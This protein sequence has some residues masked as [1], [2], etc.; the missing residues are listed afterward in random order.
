MIDFGT[1]SQR[2][3]PVILR[4]FLEYRIELVIPRDRGWIRDLSKLW[5]K[6]P[7]CSKGACQG[8]VKTTRIINW[9]KFNNDHSIPLSSP[10]VLFILFSPWL[11]YEEEIFPPHGTVDLIHVLHTLYLS[12]S[13]A[14]ASSGSVIL[15]KRRVLFWNLISETMDW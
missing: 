8:S 11:R 7:N 4:E 10:I 5:T 13:I 6:E 1:R 2:D 3:N 9:W 14:V 12:S 15:A